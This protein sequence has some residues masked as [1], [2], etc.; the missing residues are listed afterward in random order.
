MGLSTRWPEIIERELEGGGPLV[1]R[2]EKK[3]P[4]NRKGENEKK[5]KEELSPMQRYALDRKDNSIPHFAQEKG[6]VRHK[7]EAKTPVVDIRKGS[8]GEA[9]RWKEEKDGG[10]MNKALMR[11]EKNIRLGIIKN[12][13]EV[14]RLVDNLVGE[15]PHL[16]KKGDISFD[17]EKRTLSF[18]SKPFIP[19]KEWK[20]A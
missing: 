14:Q 6:T 15:Y 8:K 11:L 1:R 16:V 19:D 2:E 5:G 9:Q 13:E 12:P 3:K 18:Q 4:V 17:L 7:K 10:K 20:V